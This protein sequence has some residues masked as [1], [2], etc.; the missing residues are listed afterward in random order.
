[1]KQDQGLDTK[2]GRLHVQVWIGQGGKT[3]LDPRAAGKLLSVKHPNLQDLG[4]LVLLG[5]GPLRYRIQ[6]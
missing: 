1:M 6:A 5:G 2:V 4:K 3:L